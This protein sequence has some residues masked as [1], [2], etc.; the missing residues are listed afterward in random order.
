MNSEFESNLDAK[1]DMIQ[2]KIA[3]QPRYNRSRLGN[4]FC[5]SV[6]SVASSPN[7]ITELGKE[8]NIV[9]K[10][11][12][13]ANMIRFKNK[14]EQTRFMRVAKC[15]LAL[16]AQEASQ[17]NP[18]DIELTYMKI[19]RFLADILSQEEF[20]LLSY[21]HVSRFI[22]YMLNM[23]NG[24]HNSITDNSLDRDRSLSKDKDEST[25][26]ALPSLRKFVC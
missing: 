15:I 23:S 9:L 20:A 17:K 22:T 10:S 12:I 7:P 1:A 8:M 3:I 26:N 2:K 16:P 21:Y 25:A 11:E 13:P 18:V 14:S 5:Q 4:N 19:F 6:D 24:V